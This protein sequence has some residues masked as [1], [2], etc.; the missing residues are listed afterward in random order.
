MHYDSK[1]EI[2]SPFKH[3]KNHDHPTKVSIQRLELSY[4]FDSKIMPKLELDHK[5]QLVVVKIEKSSNM[6]MEIS[7]KEKADFGFKIE[8]SS[9]ESEGIRLALVHFL[10]VMLQ[11]EAKNVEF[12][13]GSDSIHSFHDEKGTNDPSIHKKMIKKAISD[14]LDTH[15]EKINSSSKVVLSIGSGF[16]ELDIPNYSSFCQF[17]VVWMKGRRKVKGIFVK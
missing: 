10:Q 3:S 7:G 16:K 13:Y 6:N 8:S 12:T 1:G 4:Y 9:S 5:K 14:E 2:T 11:R 15:I 17:K